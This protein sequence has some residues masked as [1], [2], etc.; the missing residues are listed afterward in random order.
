M[1]CQHWNDEWVAHLYDELEPDDERT[2]QDHLSACATCRQHMDELAISR[3]W[4]R[5]ASPAVPAA[6]PVVVLRPR[7][8]FQ[9][10]W[11]YA[12]GAACAMVVFGVGLIAGYHLLASGPG[13]LA[14]RV[15]N[16]ASPGEIL[17]ASDPSAESTAELRAQIQALLQRVDSLE[18]RDAGPD[19]SATQQAFLTRNQL[20]EALDRSEQ[21]RKV[22]RA[23]DFQFLLEEITAAEHRTGAYLDET[24]Q[25]LQV[26]ALR[27]DPRFS[28]R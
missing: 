25:A 3:D 6:P 13:E 19:P 7:G 18:R 26:V 14:S 28:E 16:G 2:L 24:R 5:Q 9:P 12:A 21:R 10:V 8:Y 15:D 4:L 27:S 23:Q 11:A 20:D 1:A 17:P 22:E